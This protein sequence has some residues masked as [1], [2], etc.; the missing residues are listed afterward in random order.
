M[1]TPHLLTTRE[2]ADRLEVTPRHVARL[3]LVPAIKLPGARGAALYSPEDVAALETERDA[4]V[5]A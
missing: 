5:A 4:E 3:G 2:V 1:H